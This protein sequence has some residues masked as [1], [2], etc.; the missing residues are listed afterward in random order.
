M[1]GREARS[2]AVPPRLLPWLV[3]FAGFAFDVAAYWPGQMSFDSAYTWWQ[4]RGGAT[5]DIAPPML[6]FVWRACDALV[7]GPGLVFALHLALFWSGLA[8]LVGA[9]RLDRW[10]TLVVMLVVAFAPVPWLLRG[11]VW[12]DVGLFSA[13]LFAVGAMARAQATEARG[14][15]VV[16]L[17]ALFYA[18]AIRYNAIAA[19]LPFA[20]WFAWLALG[21]AA[22]KRHVALLALAFFGLWF[23]FAVLISARVERKVP[24]WTAAAEWELAAISV[25]T[26]EMLLPPFM[27]GP[28]LDV[29]ELAGAFRDWSMVPMLQSTQHGMRDPFMTDYT[30][31]ELARLRTAWF[32]AVRRHPGAWIVHHWRRAVALLGVHDPSWPRELIYVDDEIRYRDNPRVLRNE[33]ALHKALMRAAARLGTTSVL[34]GWPYLLI[35]LLAAPAAWRRRRELAGACALALLA[36]T[37]LYLVPLL[38]L[39]PAELRYLGWCCLASVLAAALAWLSRSSR[40]D[41][42]RLAVSPYRN[43]R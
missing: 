25:S 22:S 13:L 26:G 3:A 21:P 16:A 43:S 23:A 40:R 14:W 1:I 29:P 9:L 33:S 28:G 5:T 11:H 12:T 37:W 31:D 4:A 38:L 27:I 2:L 19:L 15:L 7:E 35:G 6:I 10:R 18:A 8:L 32:D 24:L 30:P 39:V 36:S 17:P 41:A 34:A 20:A 42:A